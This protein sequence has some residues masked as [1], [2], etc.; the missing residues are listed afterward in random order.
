M[1]TL[2]EIVAAAVVHS[3][4]AALSHFGVLV[5]PAQI[6]QPAPAPVVEHVVARTP[7]PAEK[8]AICPRPHVRPAMVHA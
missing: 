4:T 7:R 2:T 3:S 6:A 8:L 5:E 1:T